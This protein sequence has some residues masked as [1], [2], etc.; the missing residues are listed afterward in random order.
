MISFRRSTDLKT[1]SRIS[2]GLAKGKLA[3][4]I[5]REGGC[6]AASLLR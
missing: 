5:S 6:D 1:A 2:E 3:A 4:G